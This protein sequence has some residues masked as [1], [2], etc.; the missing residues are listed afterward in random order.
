M[1]RLKNSIKYLAII[2]LLIIPFRGFLFRTSVNYSEIDHRKNVE[3]TDKKL[4]AEINNQTKGKVLNIE[5]IIELSNEITS[6][7]LAFSLH[8]VSSNANAVYISKKANCIGYSSLF[9]SIGTY[10]L[11]QQQQTDT[12]EFIHLVGAL[13][14]LGFNIHNLF[15][16]PFFKDHDYNEIINKKTHTK[17][18]VDPSLRDYLRIEYVSSR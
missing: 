12:Y 6:D 16:N 7:N 11:Q 1:K 5:E 4:I 3:L 14:V 18:F 15:D 10:M 8:R 13:D 17:L 9:N 2:I